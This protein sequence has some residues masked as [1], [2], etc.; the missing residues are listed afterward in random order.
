MIVLTRGITFSDD[1]ILNPNLHGSETT[2]PRI[3][4][5]TNGYQIITGDGRINQ[6]ASS[7]VFMAIA[8]PA[9]F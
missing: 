8:D 9:E 2:N 1:Q 4:L 3:E 6:A 5:I 7:Y